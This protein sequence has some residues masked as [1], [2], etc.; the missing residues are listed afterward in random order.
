MKI[1][2]NPYRNILKATTLLGGVEALN[3]VMAVAKSKIAALLIGVAGIGVLGVLNATIQFVFSLTRCGLDF[4]LVKEVA[5][6]PNDLKNE[7][8]SRLVG[9]SSRIVWFTGI[10]GALIILI[11]SPW[12]SQIAFGNKSY[13]ISFMI[14]SIAVFFNQLTV[15]NMAV[16]QGLKSLR[17]LA[18]ATLMTSF[19][20]LIVALG[21]YYY[22]GE[23]GIPYVI[24]GSA[25]VGFVFSKYFLYK[26]KI[27]VVNL[28]FRE[29]LSEGKSMLKLGFVLSIGGL[30]GVFPIYLIQ[31][32]VANVG[33]ITEVGFYNAGFIIIHSYVAVFFS[34]LSKDFF[35]RLSEVATDDNL[36]I[37]TVNEQALVSILLLTPLIV[38]FIA[39]APII[40]TILYTSDFL[41]ILTMLIYGIIG[42][43]FKVVSWSMGFIIIVKGNSKLYLKTEV[44]SNG[45]MLFLIAFGY[46]FYGLAGIGISYTIYYASYYFLVRYIVSRKYHFTFTPRFNRLFFI[47][48]FQLAIIL[49]TTFIE[50][51]I[52]KFCSMFIMVVISFSFAIIQLNN[53]MDL[54]LLIRNKFKNK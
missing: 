39:L 28:S 19:F 31:I 30:V 29:A 10:I 37:T 5:S 4:S 3:I 53:F 12:L 8:I 26:L 2:N 41:P 36:I 6:A 38:I 45:I 32:F 9:V 42:I 46:S 1:S 18:K 15:G 40:I 24:S 44:I 50:N 20:S 43:L 14:V 52:I 17:K 34:V 11:G 51:D 35:P 13:T 22:M 54:M 21:F 23:K 47:S 48:L 16:L 27:P 33:G 7:S 49:G 25:F